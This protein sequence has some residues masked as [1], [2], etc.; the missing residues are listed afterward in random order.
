MAS[1]FSIFQYSCKRL[2]MMK[3]GIC[4]AALLHMNILILQACRHFS[5]LQAF[6]D[7]QLQKQERK[8]QIP[9]AGGA[10]QYGIIF[11][12][13]SASTIAII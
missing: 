10:S 3:L 13:T 9:K 2:L 8:G 6:I 5:I 7:A 4:P 12:Q 1:G 11:L